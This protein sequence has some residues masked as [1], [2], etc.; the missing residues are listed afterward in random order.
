VA[1]LAEANGSARRPERLP[2]GDLQLTA[3]TAGPRS[4]RANTAS[5]TPLGGLQRDYQ[6]LG[7]LLARHGAATRWHGAVAGRRHRGAGSQPSELAR[8]LV[9]AAAVDR[10]FATTWCHRRR[11]HPV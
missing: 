1:S 11:R 3:I 10:V 9:V 7:D 2:E 8:R 4:P 6:L 5:V